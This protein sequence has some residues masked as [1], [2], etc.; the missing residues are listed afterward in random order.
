MIAGPSLRG[1]R[2]RTWLTN[3]A[4]ASCVTLVAHLAVN[5]ARLAAAQ[6]K[7]GEL[8]GHGGPVRALAIS[9]DGRIALSGSFDQSIIVWEIDTG[10]ARAVLRFHNG[11]VNAAAALPDGRFVT[12]GEDGR[13]AVWQVGIATPAQIFE[14]HKGPVAGLAVSHDGHSIASASWDGSAIVRQLESGAERRLEG[15]LGNVNAVSFLGDGRVVSAGYDGTLRIWPRDDGAAVIVQLPTPL[16]AVVA[17]RDGEIVTAGAD[18]M[19]RI[20][21][22]AGIVRAEI[23]AQRSPIIGLALSP[24]EKRVAAAAIAGSVAMI[25]RA[26]GKVLF[27]LVGPGLPV[28]SLAFRPDGRE[29]LTGGSDRLVRRWDTATG[30]PVGPLAMTRPPDMLAE[31]KGDRGAEVFRAC[32]ACHTLTSDAGNRA[33][34]S[35]HGVFGRRIATASGYNFSEDLKKLDIVWN[36]ETISRLFEIG[37]QAYTPGTKMPEQV[38]TDKADRD[39]LVRFLERATKLRP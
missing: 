11:A 27:N 2:L 30:E 29:L 19:V 5:P 4:F 8:A 34:P 32:A 3:A 15:H 38:I 35:L 28:W 7:V 16:N 24:D 14:A 13:I 22:S 21:T 18:G 10:A 12:G 25:E 39:A 37:P 31:F 26:S 36:A 6:P 17:T 33:G 23:E 20:L 9:P 1:L